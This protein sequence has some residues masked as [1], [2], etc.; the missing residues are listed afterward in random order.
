ME[1]GFKHQERCQRDEKH[2]ITQSVKPPFVVDV[3]IPARDEAATVADVVAA[4]PRGVVRHVVVA[5]NGSRDDTAARA[6]AAGARVVHE[7]SPGYGAACLAALASLPPDGDAVAFLV[8]DGSD[9]PAELPRVLTPLMEDRADLVVGSRVLGAIEP[10]AMPPFQRAGNRV[11]TAVLSL[12]FRRR[13]TDLGPFRAIR[14]DALASLGMRD[15]TWGWTLEMQV[16]AAR[17]GLRVLEVPVSWRNRRGG[18]PKIGGTLRGS[19]AA[20][21]VILS[22]LVAATLGPTFDPH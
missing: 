21:R 2:P 1:R 11:A 16:K 8:A 7:A 3:V 20:S 9:D 15:R 10:G 22:W 18:N 13:V 12:R 5:D 4:I 6:L 19:L 17:R 14:R